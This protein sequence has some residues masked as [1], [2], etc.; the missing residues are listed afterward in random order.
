MF[1]QAEQADDVTTLKTMMHK[2][3]AD[4]LDLRNQVSVL[5]SQIAT[6]QMGINAQL[7]GMSAQVANLSQQIA[8]TNNSLRASQMATTQ[9]L[10]TVQ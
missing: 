5:A 6:L 4:N 2:V 8:R 7:G 1:N 10:K 9:N 3:L